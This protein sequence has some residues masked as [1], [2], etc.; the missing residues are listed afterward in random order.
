M[1]EKALPIQLRFMILFFASVY[2]LILSG[3]YSSGYGYGWG[4]TEEM[5]AKDGEMNIQ[6]FDKTWLLTDMIS[7]SWWV[8]TLLCLKQFIAAWLR[9]NYFTVWTAKVYRKQT[10]IRVAN[11]AKTCGAKGADQ[12]S[13]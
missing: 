6:I 1:P 13:E 9:P 4:Y 8:I 10:R 5:K 11:W 12:I 2:F 3:V 7:S